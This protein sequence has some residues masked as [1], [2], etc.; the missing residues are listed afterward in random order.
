MKLLVFTNPKTGRDDEYNEWYDQV[1][2]KDLLD[3][4]GVV[5]AQRYRLRP[6]GPQGT[7]GPAHR[8]LAIYELE[9]DLDPVITEMNARA[10]QGRMAISEALDVENVLMSAYEEI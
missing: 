6:T 8:Y 7:A 9:G 10:S 4:P 1:H 2:L 3:I 5:G